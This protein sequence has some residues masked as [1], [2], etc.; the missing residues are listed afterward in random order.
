MI[1]FQPRIYAL[2]QYLHN[3]IYFHGEI[4]KY[5]GYD[6]VYTEKKVQVP[7]GV[8]NCQANFGDEYFDCRLYCWD[9]TLNTPFRHGLVVLASDEKSNKDALTKMENKVICV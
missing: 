7:R 9:D 1:I 8:F 2:Q 3:G 6:L 4:E 5:F